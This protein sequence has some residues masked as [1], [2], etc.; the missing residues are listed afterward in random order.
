[1]YQRE[2]LEEI[3][4]IFMR[5]L[6]GKAGFPSPAYLYSDTLAMW[7]RTVVFATSAMLCRPSDFPSFPLQWKQPDGKRGLRHNMV[8]HGFPEILSHLQEPTW[9][10]WICY[11]AATVCVWVCVCV[12]KYSVQISFGRAKGEPVTYWGFPDISSEIRGAPK[13]DSVETEQP[14]IT[15]YLVSHRF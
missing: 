6:E 10:Q 11:S 2:L 15:V 1:M 3:P 12:Q 7:M 9:S 14:S 8:L 13:R 4:W 5:W